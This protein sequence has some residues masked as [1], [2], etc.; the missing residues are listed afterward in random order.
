[1]RSGEIEQVFCLLHIIYLFYY[2]IFTSLEEIVWDNEY[3]SVN[4]CQI[5]LRKCT[6]RNQI[7]LPVFLI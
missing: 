4:A 6:N 5:C 2:L 1:M 3:P 7:Y